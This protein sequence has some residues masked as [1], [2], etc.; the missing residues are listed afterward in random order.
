MAKGVWNA[1]SS[2]LGAVAVRSLA[3][4]AANGPVIASA[5]IGINYFQ[6]FG[7]RYSHFHRRWIAPR[8]GFRQNGLIRAYGLLKP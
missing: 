1:G 2:W 8:S 4:P 5:G 7:K 3:G 6:H